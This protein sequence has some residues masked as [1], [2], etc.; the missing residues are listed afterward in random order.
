MKETVEEIGI[1]W[2]YH[3]TQARNLESIFKYGILPISEQKATGVIASRN[4][5]YRLDFC[6]EATSVS[7]T[8]PNYKLFYKFRNRDSSIDW[9]VIAIHPD[10][11]WEKECAFCI[12]NAAN[13]SV[14]QLAIAQRMGDSALKS[15][16]DEFPNK[17]L[18]K[19]LGISRNCPTNP[20][21]EV[22]VFDKIEPQYIA[23]L[24]FRN[25]TTLDKYS[26]N[27]P[28]KSIVNSGFFSARKDYKHW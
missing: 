6:Y 19:D 15:M 12:D 3:F 16:F 2:V 22:L 4:D 9:V 23:G 7:I 17:P 14:S 27:I 10:I 21:A 13:S 25:R 20:Q 28:V 18:R 1:K 5:L 8:F 24:I 26:A 11:L